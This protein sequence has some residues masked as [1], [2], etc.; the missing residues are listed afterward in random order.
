MSPYV[1]RSGQVD[2]WAIRLDQEEA[3]LVGLLDA[4]ERSR[5]TRFRFPEH[6]RRF[7]V[8]RAVT[9]QILAR[10]LCVDPA[11][12]RYLPGPFGKPVLAGASPQHSL[13]HSADLALLALADDTEIGVD[14][15]A[16]RSTLGLV[17]ILGPEEQ[18]AL[19]RLPEAERDLGFLRCWTRRE[20]C[21]KALGTGLPGPQSQAPFPVAAGSPLFLSLGERTWC[22]LDLPVG[23]GFV[24]SLAV[25][26]DVPRVLLRRWPECDGLG[27]A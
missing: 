7:I 11:A 27:Q 22:L 10:Y 19:A 5:A 13:S 14:V 2:L 23:A 15:E 24:A 26:G 1:L 20:S 17:E 6:R 3:P 4:E 9:R 18:A 21:L 8:R 16:I 25:A 12:I